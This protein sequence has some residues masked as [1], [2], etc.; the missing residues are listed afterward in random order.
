MDFSNDR[1]QRKGNFATFAFMLSAI[2][3]S[4]AFDECAVPAGFDAPTQFLWA[5]N[6]DRVEVLD[7]LLLLS[8]ARYA[9]KPSI[10]LI[11]SKRNAGMT[12]A[13]TRQKN[14]TSA[15]V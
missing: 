12:N 8:L 6:G 3:K 9:K 2:S 5:C 15:R 10:A 14:I 11:A 7:V 13:V 4:L 1:L